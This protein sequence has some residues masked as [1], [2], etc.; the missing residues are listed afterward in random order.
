MGR[1]KDKR[2]SRQDLIGFQ[3]LLCPKDGEVPGIPTKEE[4]NTRASLKG[5]SY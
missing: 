5:H 1:E 2:L 4:S 3:L